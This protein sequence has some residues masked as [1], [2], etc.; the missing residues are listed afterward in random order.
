MDSPS[1]L[2]I[3]EDSNVLALLKSS[4]AGTYPK[5][6]LSFLDKP[7]QALAQIDALD[8]TIVVADCIPLPGHERTLLEQVALAHPACIRVMLT[9]DLSNHAAACGA[10][11]AH[12]LL[13]KPF[14]IELVADVLERAKVLRSLPLD[15]RMRCYLGSIKSLPVLPHTYQQLVAQL[16]KGDVHLRSVADIVERD[17]AVLA[18]ILQIANA[19]FFGFSKPA[20]SAHDAVIRLGV[21]LLKN[22]VLV[23]GLFQQ[24]PGVNEQAKQRFLQ[25]AL[26]VAELS[27]KLCRELQG[28]RVMC[29][30]A[31]ITGLLHNIGELLMLHSAQHHG[32]P[33]GVEFDIS[34]PDYAVSGAY[35]LELWGFDKPLVDAVLYHASPGL[36]AQPDRLCLILYVAKLISSC[37]AQDVDPL[38]R[39][40][41]SVLKQAGIL[42][43]VLNW[44]ESVPLSID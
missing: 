10:S 4:L 9:A 24:S 26:A 43:V 11:T 33:E 21:D 27:D 28:S 42:E 18:K 19:A 44:V 23:I 39:L 16:D 6:T 20:L 37:Q 12:F 36:A 41:Q 22:L 40:D 1:V 2:V 13:A 8:P 17:Q 14:D 25:Q 32:E 3:D 29:E 5:W 34:V 15:E 35:L 30:Q 7:E 38:E 31:Y